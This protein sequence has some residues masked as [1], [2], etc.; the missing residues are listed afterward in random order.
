ML[1]QIVDI[2]AVHGERGD[3]RQRGGHQARDDER[4]HEASRSRLRAEALAEKVVFRLIEVFER[5][6]K[7]V[8]E[9]QAAPGFDGVDGAG[10]VAFAGELDRP[11]ALPVTSLIAMRTR[12]RHWI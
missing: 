12:S 5:G 3:R 7:V 9:L 1:A 10:C 11:C 2:G 8:R 6:A 4:E